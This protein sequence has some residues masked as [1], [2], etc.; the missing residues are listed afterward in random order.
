MD[1]IS[2]QES[3]KNDLVDCQEN[4]DFLN[5]FAAQCR[6]MVSLL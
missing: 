6:A 2:C 1:A 5:D 4:E 3:D